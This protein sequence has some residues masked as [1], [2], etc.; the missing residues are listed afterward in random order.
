MKFD[1]DEWHRAVEAHERW[2]GLANQWLYRLCEEHPD[3]GDPGAVYAKLLL[4]GRSY[5]AGLER[6]IESNKKTQADSLHKAAR[7]LT[8]NAAK[9]DALIAQLREVGEPIDTGGLKTILDVHGRFV[10]LLTQITTKS[11]RSFASKYL[12]FHHPVVP[13][14]DTIVASFLPKLVRKS[15]RLAVVPF[16]HKIHDDDYYWFSMRIWALYQRTHNVL[17]DG[18]TVTMR[19]LD[20]YLLGA[21]EGI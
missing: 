17:G 5:A 21:A 4:I 8:R 6:Q 14:Y 1:P 10:R 3:H 18:A 11:P 15:K 9:V 13:I 20:H 12:H 2:W 7:H 16:N 19:T